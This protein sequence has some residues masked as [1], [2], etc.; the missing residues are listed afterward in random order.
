MILLCLFYLHIGIHVPFLF[1]DFGCLCF[2]HNCAID[3]K[4]FG[5]KAIRTVF[6][7]Y[8]PLFKKDISVWILRQESN[9]FLEMLLLLNVYLSFLVFLLRRRI[10]MLMM[11]STPSSKWFNFLILFTPVAPISNLKKGM[12]LLVMKRNNLQKIVLLVMKKNNL[13]NIV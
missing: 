11:K 13:H 8:I 12:V 10:V 6:L 1:R 5:H 7:G 3:V 9:M 2:V 4:K